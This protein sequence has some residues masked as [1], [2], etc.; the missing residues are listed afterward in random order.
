MSGLVLFDFDGTL[1]DTAPDLAAA[2]NRQ[3]IRRGLPPLPFERLRPLASKGARGLL[4]AAL[5][6]TP[7]DPDFE[8]ARRQFLEDY[9]EESTANS[10][11]FPGVPELLDLLEAQGYAWGIV[12]NKTT[13]LAQPIIEHLGLTARCATIV[14]GD[15]APRAKPFPDP[16]LLAAR[17]AGYPPSRAIYV[18]DDLRDIQAAQA[19]GMPV[20][21]AAY[22]YLGAD[23]DITLW[24]ADAHAQR[25][26]DLWAI[27]QDYLPAQ[28]TPAT[29]TGA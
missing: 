11:L 7:E 16:L 26:Q 20:I 9:A 4:H 1:A 24:K 14:C 22:G 3:R 2:A 17:E 27:I 6:L 10:P 23:E 25:P 21:A 5:G 18:G 13:A 8:G 15:T 12:T 29:P 19:A 28:S